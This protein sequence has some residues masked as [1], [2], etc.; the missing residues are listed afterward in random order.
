MEPHTFYGDM[1][2]WIDLAEGRVDSGPLEDAIADAR[3]IPVLSLIHLLELAANANTAGRERVAD[4]MDALQAAGPF[5][6]I[7]HYHEVIRQEATACFKEMFGG[8]WE[9][10]VAFF[11]SF[12]EALPDA[13]P[14]IIMTVGEGMPR[15]ISEMVDA[16]LQI[17]EFQK[18]LDDCRNYP[19]L[20]QRIARTRSTRGAKKRFTDSEKRSWLAE[21]LPDHVDMALLVPI[22]DDLKRKFAE[23][24]DLT[25]CP[26]FRANWAFHEGANLDPKRAR[27]GDIPDLWHLTGAAYCDVA[28]ADKGTVEVLRKGAYDKL[29]RRNSAFPGWVRSLA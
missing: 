26:A 28:F 4:Y 22:G 23:S 27:K 24:V 29:P 17:E 2:N 12:H 3:I 13:D 5:K 1:A 21:L 6:W 18:Y 11:D 25:K 15:R 7:K 9:V 10:P 19:D 14:E 8:R 16:M 20:R